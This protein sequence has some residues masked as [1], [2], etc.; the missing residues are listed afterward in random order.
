MKIRG[1]LLSGELVEI[2]VSA[3]RIVSLEVVDLISGEEAD[4]YLLPGFIELQLNGYKGIDF[5][6]PATTP[7]EIGVAIREVRKT[8]VTA[9]CPTIIT[10]AAAHT[11]ECIANIVRAIETDPVVERAV[12]GLH[13]EGPYISPEDGPRGAHPKA[14]VRPPDLKEFERWQFLSG[15]R[16]RIL[17][18]SPEW[19]N[20]NEFIS[21]VASS[22]VLVAIGH[23]AA[24]PEQITAAVFAGAQMSTHLGNGSHAKI[25]RH[26]NYI[27]AQL[28][29]DHLWASFII[30]G[31]HLPPAVVKCLV[32]AKTVE[33]SII[34]TDAI[35]AAGLPPGYYH[36]G[37][38]E[39]EVLESRRVNLP[40]TPYLAGSVI[41]MNESIAKAVSYTGVTLAEAV[42]MATLNPARALGIEDQF[43]SIGIGKRADILIARWDP[44]R[45][46]LEVDPVTT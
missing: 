4:Q 20:A 15:Q 29:N 27:W 30:D 23:T 10:G 19:P 1:K 26:Q 3:G 9:L 21:Q 12:I 35:A 7:T 24:T 38:V 18:L 40:G 31:H 17:T 5:N 42:R 32:R 25:D 44:M 33:R 11:E 22:G 34:V 36:L 45:T 46:R 14:D 16:I 6:N 28:S 8:G 13:I 41:D 37:N 39:V 2:G 43:G